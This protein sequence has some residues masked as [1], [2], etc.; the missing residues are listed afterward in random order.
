MRWWSVLR[1]HPAFFRLWIAECISLV[2]DWF[3]VVAISVLAAT[4]GGGEGALAVATTLAAYELPMAAVRPIAGVLADR[5]DRR[6]LLIAVHLVQAVCTAW[7][8]ERALANDLIGL[9]A[10]VFVRSSVSGL[11]WPARNGAI[12][13][14]VSDED[15]LTANA[16]GGASWSAMFAVGMA[17]GGL[18]A[19]LGVPLALVLDA[20]TFLGAAGLIA[21]LP[22]MPPRRDSDEQ[23][24]APQRGT[25]GAMFTK[26]RGD[27]VEGVSIAVS[28]SDRFRAVFSKTPYA[29][30]GGAGVVLLNL[31]AQRAPFAGSAALTLGVLQATR[32]LGTGIGPLLVARA[33]DR[34]W[35]LPRAW[36]W[37]GVIGVVGILALGLF[38]GGWWCLLPVWMWGMGSG[39][40][41]MIASAELQRHTDDGAIGRLSGLDL[42]AVET[43]FALSALMG[44]LAIEATGR[45]GSAAAVGLTLGACGW[46]GLVVGLAVVA[47]RQRRAQAR[48][49]TDDDR[50]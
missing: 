43:S 48:I 47:R 1:R 5:F 3:S 22:Q 18:V 38:D 25:I 27:F 20:V 29:L 2:G 40:N 42:L 33:V 35:P 37:T 12:R 10:L 7:M 21:T 17:L 9:Q 44:G 15:R 30:M 46:L 4:R 24:T 28:S 45:I 36:A 16:L 14:L 41:W 31:M 13:R 6:S 26:A 49:V 39:S 8:A 11:D 32:G 19:T 34:G 50:P 23:N